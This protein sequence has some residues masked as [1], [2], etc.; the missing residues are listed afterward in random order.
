M[1]LHEKRCSK[2]WKEK[3]L[4]NTFNFLPFKILLIHD[5]IH[6]YFNSLPEI[7]SKKKY[8]QSPEWQISC[9]NLWVRK[10]STG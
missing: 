9:K 6:Y 2:H 10:I 4:R 3:T 1:H 8:F 7:T 5:S